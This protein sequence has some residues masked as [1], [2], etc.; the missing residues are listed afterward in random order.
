MAAVLDFSRHLGGYSPEPFSA[1]HA[2]LSAPLKRFFRSYRLSAAD[3]EDLTQ[4]VFVRLASPGG[5]TDLL[6]PEAYVFTLARNLVRDRARRLHTRAV[7]RS[8]ALDE[9]ELRCGRPTPDQRLE[10]EQRLADVE[11]VLAALKPRTRE[12]FVSHRVHG[13]SYATIATQMDISVSMVE[14]HIMSAL[15]ALRAISA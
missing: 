5:Q 10:L 15:I 6:K 11:Q 7:A 13:E 14:K 2:R 8:V 9:V 1:L 3:V 4:D 12:A